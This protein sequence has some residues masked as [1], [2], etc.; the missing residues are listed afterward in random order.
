M[1][2]IRIVLLMSLAL[3]TQ[4]AAADT[5][6]NIL[7]IVAEDMSP[8][9]GAYGDKVAQTPNI[10]ALARQGIRFTRVFTTAGVCAPSRTALISGMH[11]V[12]IGAHQMRTSNGPIAY[13]TVP[14]AQMKAFPELFRQAGYATANFAKRDYQFGEPFS[15]WDSDTG[16]FG[17]DLEPAIW[18]NLPR[19]KPFFAMVNLMSTHESRIYPANT[20]G[21]G[22][23]GP[24]FEQFAKL[25]E[26]KVEHVTD[27]NDV[28]IPPWLV[29]KPG[30][31]EM[32]AQHYDNIHFMDGEVGRILA[33]LEK[34][35]L[36]DNTIVIWTTDHG[37]LLPRA[38]RAIYD[39]GLRV[40]M[41]VR[42]PDGR[43]AGAVNDRLISFLDM[44]P[45]LLKIGGVALPGWLQGVDFLGNQKRDY[46]FSAR[47]RMD[48]TPDMQRS[49]SDGRYKYVRNFMP[50]LEFFRPLDFRDSLPAMQELWAGK[51]AGTLTPVQAFYFTKPRPVEELY[52]TLND[53]H[54]TH[55]LAADPAMQER[56][57]R[58]RTA[59]D[60]WRAEVGDM[61]DIEETV[62]IGQMWPGMKQPATAAP[63]FTVKTNAAGDKE[64][65]LTSATEGASIGYRIVSAGSEPGAWQLYTGAFQAPAGTTVEAKAVRY[66]YS[67]SAETQ[68]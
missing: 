67:V 28:A 16:N 58:M 51:D 44:A 36:A 45:T 6:P 56:L 40:P 53:P 57:L 52:D 22:S 4:I 49:A 19:D 12:S 62:M 33:E 17:S 50:E 5:R 21:R 25:R 14:P 30:T 63:E 8:R 9:V 43:L 61:G 10:D 54:E 47:D 2:V 59:L 66:G 31:R 35:G 15:I 27:R 68:Q 48:K 7:L 65:T 32:I 18:R 34:D 37:D 42:F 29:D 24:V 46:V 60:A 11:Q 20:P 55:N 38:K 13:E 64:V 1:S 26:M 23:F 41:I 39:S 3:V